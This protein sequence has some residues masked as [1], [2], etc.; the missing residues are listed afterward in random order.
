MKEKIGKRFRYEPWCSHQGRKAAIRA[1]HDN[2]GFTLICF[3]C[4]HEVGEVVRAGNVNRRNKDREVNKEHSA[5]LHAR[6]LRA[7]TMDEVRSILG[8][9]ATPRRKLYGGWW[10]EVVVD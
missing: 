3:S 2:L 7:V 8:A 5:L 9:T 10:F 6:I 1:I 4:P